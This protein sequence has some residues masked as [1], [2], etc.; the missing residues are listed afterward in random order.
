MPRLPK[1]QA[2]PGQAAEIIQEMIVSGELRD[3]IP[4]ER[5]L[6]AKLQIGRD[7]LRAALEIL[8][9]NGTISK[10]E[11]GKRR[12]ILQQS[13]DSPPSRT[14]HIAFLSPKELLHLPPKL[15]AE[16]D[17]LRELL[18]RSGYELELVSPGI[19][20]LQNPATK[21]KKLTR[22]VKADAWILYQCPS[23]IQQWFN[24][25]GLP[26]L[27]RGYPQD[28]ISLPCIDEDWQ[29]AAFHAGAH[30][31]RLGHKRVGLM[32]PQ[33]Q[34]AG[35][36]ATE[37]G[38]REAMEK[39]TTPGSVYKVIEKG[40]LT[41][42]SRAIEVTFGLEDPP[43]A[44]ITTRSRHLLTVI[45]WLAQQKACIPRDLSLV[46]LSSEPWFDHLYPA[47]SHYQS[48]PLMIA[49][50]VARK[51]LQLANGEFHSTRTKL[52]FPEFSKGQ[53]VRKLL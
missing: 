22:D 40:T 36:E 25:Q 4:G 2:L 44:L 11:H 13:S 37:R 41:S 32:V 28:G 43:T 24:S 16:F 38:L 50:T 42:I 10:R 47:I 21:L 14:K 20:H 31:K 6:A 39:G 30:L 35:L 19:F 33:T 46:S 26:A 27:I 23:V 51:V 34:L 1:R 12:Q 3:L 45:S 7:T 8:E 9:A 15:M 49:R 29:S 5:T 48:D 53:S 17:T 18:Q 52:L